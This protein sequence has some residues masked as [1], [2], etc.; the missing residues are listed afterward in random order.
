MRKV[1]SRLGADSLCWLGHCPIC[2]KDHPPL[3]SPRCQIYLSFGFQI[4]GNTTSLLKFT[5]ASARKNKTKRACS[6][7]VT[8]LSQNLSKISVYYPDSCCNSVLFK[9]FSKVGSLGIKNNVFCVLAWAGMFVC[10]WVHSL[11]GRWTPWLRREGRKGGGKWIEGQLLEIITVPWFCSL[12]GTGSQL[13]N[14]LAF[15]QM[16]WFSENDHSCLR[17]TL[18]EYDLW[19]GFTELT[20][21]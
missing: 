4:A 12:L 6:Q 8:F 10:F 3:L 5:V 9:I 14:E 11:V 7:R 13:R 15:C 17:Y 2:Q 1:R 19:L 18:E 16:K 21:W 20:S